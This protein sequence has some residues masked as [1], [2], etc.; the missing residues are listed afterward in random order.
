MKKFYSALFA[1]GAALAITPAT[2]ADTFD[3]TYSDSQ[4]LA[5]TG[6]LTGSSIASGEYAITSGTIDI[7]AGGVVQGSGTLYADPI[8]PAVELSNNIGG[9][10]ETSFGGTNMSFDDLLFVGSNPQLDDNGLIFIVDG[11][12]ISIWGNSANNYELWEGNWAFDDGGGGTFAASA[13][14]PGSL[15]LLGTGLLGLA[16]VAFR[17]ARVPGLTF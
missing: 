15:L 13:P 10:L 8:S 6:T 2:L 7:T 4:G 12:G 11:V 14:E 17:K 1:I 3:F 5:A 9:A 16:L